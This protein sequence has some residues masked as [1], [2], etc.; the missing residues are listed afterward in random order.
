ER[1]DVLGDRGLGERQGLGSPR[2]GSQLGDLREDFE[3]SQIHAREYRRRGALTGPS[4]HPGALRSADRQWEPAPPPQQPPPEAGAAPLP[5]A[6]ALPVRTPTTESW[7]LTR[8]LSHV[9]HA[10]AD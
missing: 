2:K 7:R 10:T 6:N 9:G 4:T 8:A 3:L 1:A 5:E